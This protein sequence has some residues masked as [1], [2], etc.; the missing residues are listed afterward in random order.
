MRIVPVVALLQALRAGCIGHPAFLHAR[1]MAGRPADSSRTALRRMQQR[2]AFFAS[3]WWL[4][5]ARH[6]PYM[7]RRWRGVAGC[8]ASR[9]GGA[10]VA[11]GRRWLLEKS[12]T[13]ALDRAAALNI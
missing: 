11:Q 8:S 6:A 13:R 7:A 1:G 5:A 4:T 10:A 12:L 9:G 3:A 2:H